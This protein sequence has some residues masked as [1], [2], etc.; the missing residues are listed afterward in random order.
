MKEGTATD[1]DAPPE[2]LD[3]V[4]QRI[5]DRFPARGPKPAPTPATDSTP[6]P[7]VAVSRITA[8]R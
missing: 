5:R 8:A 2:T 7:G 6:G 3:A 1:A 4:H